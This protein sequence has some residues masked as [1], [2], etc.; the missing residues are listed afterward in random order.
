M[1]SA[2]KSSC[3]M[4]IRKTYWSI[5]KTLD[6]LLFLNNNFLDKHFPHVILLG[7]FCKFSFLGERM[8]ELEFRWMVILAVQFLA[9]IFILNIILFKPLLKIFRERED[10][11]KGSL[12]ASQEMTQKK[13]ESIA[14]LNRELAAARARAKEAFEG[15]RNEGL[16][17]QK[18]VL[19]EAESAA[20]DML[21]KAREELKTEAVRAR[22]S[23]RADVD[24]FSDEIVRKLVEA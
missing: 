15:L 19:S 2:H 16:D 12:E 24:S 11:V 23:M 22:E 8:L 6:N 9:L 7:A 17:R 18:E 10:T 13:D 14:T 21:Q 3:G 4:K 1:S 20:T 5:G